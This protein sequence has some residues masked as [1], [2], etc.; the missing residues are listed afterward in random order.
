MSQEIA[1]DVQRIN[2]YFSD[3]IWGASI[4]IPYDV[5]AAMDRL[6]AR[7]PLTVQRADA[8]GTKEEKSCSTAFAENLPEIDPTV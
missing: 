7:F 5:L 3:L 2:R 1:E 4:I 6:T 8:S